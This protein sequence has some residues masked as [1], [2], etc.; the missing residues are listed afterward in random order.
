MF[1]PPTTRTRVVRVSPVNRRVLCDRGMVLLEPQFPLDSKRLA[2]HYEPVDE[3][4]PWREAL[5]VGE[6]PRCCVNPWNETFDSSES[7]V[8]RSHLLAHL[9]L[10]TG[11]STVGLS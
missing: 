8:L 3:I 7:G 11:D 9:Q 5:P 6:S 4:R 2:K 1:E 10:T